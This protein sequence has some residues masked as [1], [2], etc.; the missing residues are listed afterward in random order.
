MMREQEHS[1]CH[2]ECA[3]AMILPCAQKLP[4]RHHSDGDDGVQA[5]LQ[6]GRMPRPE[7]RAE[8]VLVGAAQEDAR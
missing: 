5:V 2:E 4:A 7:E 8:P 6:H 1:V 3:S